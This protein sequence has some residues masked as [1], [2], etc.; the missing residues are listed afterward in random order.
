M[1]IFKCW[2]YFFKDLII[3]SMFNVRFCLK[4]KEEFDYFYDNIVVLWS[5]IGSLILIVLFF[6][7]NMGVSVC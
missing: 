3:F 1:E 7:K 2:V 5:I 6:I 4:R